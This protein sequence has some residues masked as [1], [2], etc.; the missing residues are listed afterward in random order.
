MLEWIL[1]LQIMFSSSLSIQIQTEF[2]T[3][4]ECKA[5]LASSR[6]TSKGIPL[7]QLRASATCIRKVTA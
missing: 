6:L 2:K 4:D 3:E 5:A 1:V 7:D